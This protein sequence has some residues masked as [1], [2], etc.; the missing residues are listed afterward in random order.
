[1]VIQW[2]E[3]PV[4]DGPWVVRA[5]YTDR[6]M[7]NVLASELEPWEVH[8]DKG[9]LVVEVDRE[10]YQW[11]LNL[12]FRVEIDKDLTAKLNQPNFPLPGQLTGIPGY[13]CYRTVEETFTTAQNL[14]SMYPNLVSWIDVGDSWEKTNLGGEPGYD[15]FVL[16][17]T[18]DQIA[19]SKPKLFVM[20]S[21]HAREYAPAELNTRFAEFLAN[22]YDIDP[23]VTWLLDYHEVHLMLQANPDGRKRAETATLWRKNADNN[24][25]SNTNSRGVDLNRNFEFQWGCCFGSSG[26]QCSETF[27][28]PT[29]GSEPETQAIQNYVRAQFPDQRDDPLGSPAPPDATG[30]FLDIHSYS[31]LV[32]WPWGFTG[33]PAPN[34]EA[35]QTLGRKFA[36]F[37]NYYPDQAIGLY[38]TDGTTDDFAYGELGLA[39]YTF[40][41]GTSFFQDCNSF[42]STILPD[43]MDALLYAA[44]VVRTPYLTPAG[45]EIVNLNAS[46]VSASPGDPINITA[47]ANDARFSSMNGLEPAQNIAAAEYYLDIP[48]WITTT[49]PVAY[50]MSAADGNFDASIEDL[51]A[52]IDTSV[53]SQGRHTVFVR[54]RDAA[55]NWGPVSAEFIF[56][57]AQFSLWMPLVTA[58]AGSRR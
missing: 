24:F 5:H 35:L 22:N 4:G 57:S 32:L 48:P 47:T 18:N 34:S 9:Y 33:T 37:N 14:V 8:H 46:P 36:Y 19:V 17:L 56:T 44:K 31:E 42:E 39:A 49:T 54:G 45:P 50:P 27:R 51:T 1:M 2:P 7:V 52:S 43:N 16:R 11:L 6:E 12:G 21:V 38:P 25:C 3:P 20:S 28:G 30:I 23:D 29:P 26:N 15:I 58:Q 10:S 40:E 53:L 41:L 13:A 55:G